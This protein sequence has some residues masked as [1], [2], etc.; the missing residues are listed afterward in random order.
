MKRERAGTGVIITSFLMSGLFLGVVHHQARKSAEED[1]RQRVILPLHVG[2]V[3]EVLEQHVDVPTV[4]QTSAGA[5]ASVKPLADLTATPSPEPSVPAPSAVPSEPMPAATLPESIQPATASNNV[6]APSDAAAIQ[7]PSALPIFPVTS[8]EISPEQP[9]AAAPTEVKS[10]AD[11][12]ATSQGT[13]L[14]MPI[15]LPPEPVPAF[16]LK[17]N[18]Q[19]AEEEQ[20]VVSYAKISPEEAAH[21]LKPLAL[22]HS[23]EAIAQSLQGV[24][25]PKTIAIVNKVTQDADAGLG[26]NDILELIFALARQRKSEQADIDGLFS[27][28]LDQRLFEQGESVLFVAA[29]H[30]ADII[31]PLVQWA[32]RYMRQLQDQASVAQSAFAAMQESALQDAISKN[33]P[34]K[35]QTLIEQ[36][37]VPAPQI[38]QRLLMRVIHEHKNSDFIG[39][40]SKFLSDVNAALQDDMTLLMMAVQQGDIKQVEA[41]LLLPVDVNLMLSPQVGTALQLAIAKEL[42]ETE[43]LDKKRHAAIITL[44]RAHGA[45]EEISQVEAKREAPTQ[46]Q[47]EEDVMNKGAKANSLF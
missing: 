32:H 4:E 47:P 39:M 33:N 28:L 41:I 17:E 38:A 8:P 7:A 20:E 15:A 35:M 29:E 31:M 36:G 44:L 13:S 27:Y 2:K 6:T 37:I 9:Q 46:K 14:T 26:R 21:Y 11:L 42:E 30:Y 40:L 5:P 34:K 12:T 22:T 25:L 10:P 19:P 1:A 43:A 16:A 3:S 24:P 23:V 18:P 45:R